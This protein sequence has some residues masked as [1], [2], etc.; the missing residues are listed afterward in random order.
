M[1]AKRSLGFGQPLIEA[2]G[3]CGNGV[4]IGVVA[5]GLLSSSSCHIRR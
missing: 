3:R 2:I 5:R 1:P 4:G